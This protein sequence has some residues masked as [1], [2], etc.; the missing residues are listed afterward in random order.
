MKEKHRGEPLEFL[1]GRVF[2]HIKDLRHASRPFL[3]DCGHLSYR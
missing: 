2:A 1:V 3:V